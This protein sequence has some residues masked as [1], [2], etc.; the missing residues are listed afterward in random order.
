LV[1]NC[2]LRLDS[3]ANWA[4]A[5]L[6]QNA[7]MLCANHKC[8]EMVPLA[9]TIA[10]VWARTNA[11]AGKLAIALFEPTTDLDAFACYDYQAAQTGRATILERSRE[12]REIDAFAHFEAFSG[13]RAEEDANAADAF[14]ENLRQLSERPA[15]FA[16]ERACC[17][18][19]IAGLAETAP[20]EFA[21]AIASEYSRAAKDWHRNFHCITIERA[22]WENFSPADSRQ[23][24]H[25][26]RDFLLCV[27][28]SAPKVKPNFK[29]DQHKNALV[30]SI[31][32]ANS[33]RVHETLEEL[34]QKLVVSK[35]ISLVMRG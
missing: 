23:Q 2:G 15:R 10:V 19:R 34:Q 6:A 27:D 5:P 35:P 12:N 8:P 21:D 7:L 31:G 25:L 4:D 29:F 3:A 16:T 18:E 1:V 26:A 30:H 20:C 28:D 32:G 24:L 17:R 14:L 13:Q 11:A 9:A 33:R 22:P